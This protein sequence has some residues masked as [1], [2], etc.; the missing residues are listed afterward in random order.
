MYC[1]HLFCVLTGIHG[2]HGKQPE[3][4]CPY[5]M[6]GLTRAALPAAS[7][8]GHE[9]TSVRCGAPDAPADHHGSRLVTG[10]LGMTLCDCEHNSCALSVMMCGARSSADRPH[11]LSYHSWLFAVSKE[12]LQHQVLARLTT[13]LLPAHLRRQQQQQQHSSAALPSCFL[14][15]RGVFR[16]ACSVMLFV[17]T[18]QQLQQHLPLASNHCGKK[19]AGAGG[20]VS[21]VC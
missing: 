9:C 3:H 15:L 10:K 21:L 14:P 20:E 19:A 8:L 5:M 4:T 2:L 17:H 18:Q 13:V 12:G 6:P 1:V 16:T 7:F 11:I